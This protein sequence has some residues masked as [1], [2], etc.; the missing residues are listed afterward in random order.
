[1]YDPEQ[2]LE[3][4]RQLE[5]IRATMTGAIEQLAEKI[6]EDSQ[7]VKLFQQIMD[8]WELIFEMLEEYQSTFDE[9]RKQEL[10]RDAKTILAAINKA[11]NKVVEIAEGKK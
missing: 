3:N 7:W 1:M 9:E 10:K 5:E 2:A 8:C 4:Q 11:V 6:G